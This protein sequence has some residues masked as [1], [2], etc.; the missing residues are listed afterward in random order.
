MLSRLKKYYYRLNSDKFISYLRSQGITIGKGCVFRSP[1]TTHIDLMRPSLIQIGDNVDMNVGF[2]IMA[3]DF[4][5]RVFLFKY[6]EFLN[7][8]GHIKIGNNIYFGM[9]VTVL[10]G[11]TIGDNCIIGAGSIVT[12]DIPSNSVASG[13][14]AKIVSSLDEY[15]ER[16]KKKCLFEACEYANSIRHRY[17]REPLLSEFG[18]EFGLFVDKENVDEYL[19]VINIKGRLRTEYN[20]W[21][22]THK[23]TFKSFQEFLNYS[24]EQDATEIIVGQ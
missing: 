24:K 1:M 17:G 6:G 21:M 4:T 20:R 3:H 11:V 15:F 14:P 19:E 18:P 12:K 13:V 22:E 7:S 10:K 8:S 16:R 23:K 2:T 9:N 5:S